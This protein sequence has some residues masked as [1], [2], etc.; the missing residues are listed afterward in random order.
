MQPDAKDMTQILL[1]GSDAPL[2]EG[3]AQSLAALGHAPVVALSLHEA[4]ELASQHP[5]LIAVVSRM[6]ASEASSEM[7]GI[8]LAPGGA[9]VLYRSAGNLTVTLPPA[10]QRAVLADLTLP[11]ERNRLVAL[12]AHVQ[13]RARATG[14]GRVS[15]PTEQLEA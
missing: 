6:L 4:R 13:E 12:V 8:P 10:L 15:G 1:V 2:L 3:L 7:L 14:R 11:L 5:P 9:L